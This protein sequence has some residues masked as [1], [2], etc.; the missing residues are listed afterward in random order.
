MMAYLLPDP[1]QRA[2]AAHRLHLSCLRYAQRYGVPSYAPKEAGL[3]LWLPPGQEHLTYPRMFQ[4]GVAQFGL[5]LGLALPRLL[6]AD[7]ALTAMHKKYAPGKHW[8]LFLLAVD[9]TFHG[10]G[11]GGALLGEGQARA[12]EQG[13][14]CYLETMTQSNVAFYTKRG[15]VVQEQREVAPEL[16]VWGLRWEQK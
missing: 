16:T 7:A 14:P 6:K 11:V 10:Q 12:A 3:A 1:V 13:L 9:P 15:F 5:S 2:K 8:Y 4:T